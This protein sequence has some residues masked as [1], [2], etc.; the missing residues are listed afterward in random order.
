MVRLE[1]MSEEQELT[2]RLNTIL[3]E[4]SDVMK[5]R[6]ERIEQIRTQVDILENENDDMHKRINELIMDAL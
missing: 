3:I 2:S 5:Q 6:K 1:K 4:L